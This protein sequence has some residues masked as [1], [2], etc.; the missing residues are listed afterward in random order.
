[1][2]RPPS[3]VFPLGTPY[4]APAA[5]TTSP[6]RYSPSESFPIPFA[7]PERAS[8][9]VRV[10]ARRSGVSGLRRGSLVAKWFGR[11]GAG[12]Y[13]RPWR[14]GGGFRGAREVWCPA[15]PSLEARG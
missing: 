2:A 9:K 12:C 8:I 14:L 1:M 15:G 4:D 3:S 6:T 13:L 5:Q 7:P 11:A 10:L